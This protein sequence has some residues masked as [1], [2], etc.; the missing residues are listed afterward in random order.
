MSGTFTSTI[1][2]LATPTGIGAIGV[3][4]VSGPET[5]PIVQKLF[6]GKNLSEQA[7]H[8]LHFGTIRDEAG[9]IVDEVLLSLFRTPHSYTREDSIEISCHGSNFIIQKILRLLIKNGCRMAQH[10]EFTQ[11]AFLNGQLDLAQAEAVA[12]LIASDTEVSHRA[13]IHQIRGGF[14][15]DI[16][17]LREQLIHFA[18]LIELELDF[19][20]EDVEFA[21]RTQLRQ[22]ISNIRQTLRPLIDSFELGNVLKEGVPVAI[23]GPPNAGKSTLLNA[24]L[25]EEKAIV[26][27]IAGTTRDVIEDTLVLSGIKF[28]VL[29]TAGI[30][31][32]S[33]RVEAIGVERSLA[34]LDRAE[35]ILKLSSTDV[36]SAE[37]EALFAARVPE[38][39]RV[40][41]IHTKADVYE[42]PS[43]DFSISAATG[44]GIEELKQRL[45][46]R[47]NLQ[48]TNDTVVTN[49]RHYEHLTATDTA[50]QR[51][52][53]GLDAGISQDWLA[54][55]IRQSLVHLGEITG[56]ITTD[57]LLEN[58][59]SKF[60]IGK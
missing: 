17:Q 24:L 10:G 35:I 40:I 2:A 3:I 5:F 26:T 34:A 29:D 55:D 50:L 37:F 31:E 15:K 21:D 53:E 8:T 49:L 18:S 48:R 47:V 51:A 54:M 45:V 46:D 23:V 42:D 12:D 27:E 7:T 25:N 33:D 20:E 60:C 6:R 58:I 22:L 57:D 9:Q 4:R 1:C 14:S 30:R 59:F 11:R 32:T 44:Q 52:L 43:A 28:R 36:A 13:A 56:Q 16:A 19:G 39:G 41:R 38:P